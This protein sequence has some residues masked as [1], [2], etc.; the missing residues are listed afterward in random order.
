MGSSFPREKIAEYA[1]ETETFFPALLRVVKE[2]PEYN[3]AAFLLEY[4]IRSL[5]MLAG[6]I[7]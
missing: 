6:R 4:Q 2:R 3:N 7:C 5:L 1:R